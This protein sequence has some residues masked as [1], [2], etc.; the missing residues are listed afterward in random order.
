LHELGHLHE[1][2]QAYLDVLNHD[3]DERHFSSVDRA[4]TGF[5]ARQNLAVVASDMG[6]LAEAERQWRE[7]VREVPRYRQGWRGMGETMLRAGRFAELDSMA[8]NLTT[9]AEL[10]VEGML[11][12]SRAAKAQGALAAARDALD[13]ALAECPNDWAALC[14]ASQ[15]HFEHGTTD[16][17]DKALRALLD[18]RP[19]D[20]SAHHNR[21]IVLMKARR[22]DEAVEAYRQ[23]LRYRPNYAGTYL[24]V[25]YALRDSGRFDEA[26][27]AWHEAA[28]LAPNDRTA[29][30]E[31]AGLRQ[32]PALVGR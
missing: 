5:K 25:G 11:I 22:F 4:L 18:R 16:E 13:R 30:A 7:V 10:R 15:F 19:D 32:S 1:A 2:R 20:A 23:S 27:Q 28:R 26:A 8:K 24:N 21:G 31:L 29:R 17:A 12:K 9:V 6:D 3:G 14:E